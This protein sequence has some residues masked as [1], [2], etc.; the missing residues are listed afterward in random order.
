MTTAEVDDPSGSV[1]KILTTDPVRGTDSH[2]P[3]AAAG[4]HPSDATTLGGEV[5]NGHSKM[6]T[7]KTL[8]TSVAAYARKKSPRNCTPTKAGVTPASGTSE[9]PGAIYTAAQYLE[10][11]EQRTEWP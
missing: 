4:H 6:K 9:N 1:V 8:A 10:M 7:T 5:G 3:A 11:E 2:L